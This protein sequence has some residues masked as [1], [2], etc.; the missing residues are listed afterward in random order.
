MFC[1]N[2]IVDEYCLLEVLDLLY[3]RTLYGYY[4]LMLMS[5]CSSILEASPTKMPPQCKIGHGT[6]LSAKRVDR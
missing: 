2:L 1:L 4:I 3:P 5:L 6:K